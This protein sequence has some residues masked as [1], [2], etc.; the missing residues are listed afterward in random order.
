MHVRMIALGVAL[1]VAATGVAIGQNAQS[2]AQRRAIFKEMGDALAPVGPMVR[3]QAPF[4]LE[5][6]QNALAVIERNAQ[7]LPNAFPPDSRTGDTNALPAAFERLPEVQA[8]FARLGSQATAARAAIRDEASFR[9]TMPGVL[10]ICAE[11]HRGF[12]RPTS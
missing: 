10:G 3:S 2:I 7:R 6:V 4:Q 12:R 5:A 11:C 8:L 1:A 9:A